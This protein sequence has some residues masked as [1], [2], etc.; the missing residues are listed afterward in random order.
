MYKII[1]ADGKEY[2]PVNADQIRQW[3]A[4]GR[5]NA[6]TKAQ[7]E[8]SAE[9]TPLG[10]FPEFNEALALQVGALGPAR[11]PTNQA[12]MDQA[13]RKVKPPAIC[14]LITAVL[15]ALW[16]LF[17]LVSR[18]VLVRSDTLLENL[19]RGNPQAEPIVRLM[20]GPVGMGVDVLYLILAGLVVFGGIRMMKLQSHGLA[21]ASSIIVMLPCILPCCAL[22]LP[23]G[24]W[25]LIVLLQPDVKAQFH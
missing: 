15:Y 5:V 2:G 13:L 11:A 1:G 20:W 24:I 7:A 25:S 14:L 6:Q 4:E 3:I 9:W 21:I 22:G 12:T 18:I 23:V 19:V 17:D 8:G 10:E 16:A